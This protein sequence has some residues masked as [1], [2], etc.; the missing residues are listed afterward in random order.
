MT[1]TAVMES[2]KIEA[3]GKAVT[4]LDQAKALVIVT[5][6]DRT[7][8]EEMI[9]AAKTLEDEIFKYLDPPREKA[10]E[11]Y[12]YHKKR[13]DDA[14]LPIQNARKE[15]KQKCIAFDQEQERK[16]KEE[17]AKAEAEARKRA[18]DEALAM[19]AQAEQEGQPEVAEAILSEPV[20]VAP[21]IVP[22]SAPA[23]SRL[24]AGRT[25][26][27]ASVIDLKKLCAAI[28]NGTASTEFVMGLDK[29]KKT[30]IISSPA[31]NKAAQAMKNTMNIPGVVGKSKTV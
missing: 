29:D 12:K 2:P 4:L 13:L 26:W 31:L 9:Q 10:Y 5:N 28:G 17:Q 22:R 18:E 21:V 25:V 6:E 1:Q 30:G 19:A 15:F 14:L 24:S 20:Q 7:A 8:A 16:R 27:Y 23:P 11:D 3:E